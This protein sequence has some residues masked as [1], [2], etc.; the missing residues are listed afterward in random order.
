MKTRTMN[1]QLSFLKTVQPFDQLP[2]EALQQ[3]SAG[4]SDVS[5]SAGTRIFSQGQTE[6]QNLYVIKTGGIKLLL[7][8]EDDREVL[9]EYRGP[10]DYFGAL[11]IITETKANLGVEAIKDTSCVLVSQSDFHQ[12]IETYP[13][14][15]AFYLKSFCERYIHSAHFELKKRRKG[16]AKTAVCIFS[17]RISAG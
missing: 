4:L 10:G 6:V 3:I 12:F 14:F 11:G 5:F 16:S 7:N 2:E 1:K 9:E 17:V 8:D 13:K 15:S